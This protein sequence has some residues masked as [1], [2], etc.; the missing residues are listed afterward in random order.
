MNGQ[1]DEWTETW[2]GT[3]S[4]TKQWVRVLFQSKRC[5]SRFISFARK[6]NK[7]WQYSASKYI[8]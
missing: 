5:S 7:Q 3:Q 6:Y 4:R 1:I 2:I 8:I